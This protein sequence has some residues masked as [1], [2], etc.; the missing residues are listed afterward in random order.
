MGLSMMAFELFVGPRRRI[1][2]IAR[3]QALSDRNRDRQMTPSKADSE[4]P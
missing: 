2:Y 4:I 1:L 3:D